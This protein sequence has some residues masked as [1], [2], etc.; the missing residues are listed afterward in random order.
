M[1]TKLGFHLGQ[2]DFKNLVHWEHHTWISATHSAVV[3]GVHVVT[4]VSHC[5]RISNS[6]LL[7]VSRILQWFEFS[8][9]R[10]LK[11]KTFKVKETTVCLS[12][13]LSTIVFSDP[14]WLPA[15]GKMTVNLSKFSKSSSIARLWKVLMT[16]KSIFQ[17]KITLQ[18]VTWH[19]WPDF[20]LT[21]PFKNL[22]WMI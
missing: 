9:E 16:A 20:L 15:S 8:Y 19:W 22:V 4:N 6:A 13:Y 5:V 2:V 3:C 14:D 7:R 11:M 10:F 1:L 17:Q 12:S 21:M 18:N